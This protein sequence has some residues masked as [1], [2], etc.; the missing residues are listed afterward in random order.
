[1]DKLLLLLQ[2]NV[3]ILAGAAVAAVTALL[4]ILADKNETRPLRVLLEM[5]IC[6]S[7]AVAAYSAIA[8]LGW[9]SRWLIFIG[10]CIG[11]LGSYNV[12]R[13]ALKVIGDNYK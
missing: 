6:A 7:M 1:M 9:D 4:R 11:Y 10:S 5:L 13:L 3:E 2:D 12:R 8:A